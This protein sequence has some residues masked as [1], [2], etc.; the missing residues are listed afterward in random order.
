MQK[1]KTNNTN[2]YTCDFFFSF[3]QA[4]IFMILILL[5]ILLQQRKDL[6][7]LNLK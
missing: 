1:T 6:F 3:F 4:D 2:K 7:Q 5:I